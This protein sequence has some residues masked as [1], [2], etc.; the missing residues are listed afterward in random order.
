[1]KDRER[2]FNVIMGERLSLDEAST[3]RLASRVPLP[4]ELGK[5]LA[6][7]LEVVRPRAS[8]S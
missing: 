7:R 5:K 8:I 2:W 3:D 1:V 6:M 4:P